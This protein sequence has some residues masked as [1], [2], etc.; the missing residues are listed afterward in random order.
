MTAGVGVIGTGVGPPAVGTGVGVAGR[1][2]TTGMSP[3]LSSLNAFNE[4][5]QIDHDER[6]TSS[7]SR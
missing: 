7:S 2:V 3:L 5:L 1:A 6:M 4:P